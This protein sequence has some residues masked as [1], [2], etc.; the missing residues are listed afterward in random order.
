MF[1]PQ[2]VLGPRTLQGERDWVALVSFPGWP[3]AT[4]GER[5]ALFLSATRRRICQGQ[6]LTGMIVAAAW[7]RRWEKGHSELVDVRFTG[8]MVASTI[9]WQPQRGEGGGLAHLLRGMMNSSRSMKA[10]QL[11]CL[12]AR[13][14]HSLYQ[15]VCS[16]YLGPGARSKVE[17]A[18]ALVRLEDVPHGALLAVLPDEERVHADPPAQHRPVTAAQAG[19]MR[20]CVHVEGEQ[21]QPVVSMHTDTRLLIRSLQMGTWPRK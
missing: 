17:H 15:L 4:G 2:H 11:C 3:R 1:E 9:A 12:D 8:D 6:L 13:R 16:G 21:T 5:A 20:A 14:A 19:C 10:T 7:C 18:H